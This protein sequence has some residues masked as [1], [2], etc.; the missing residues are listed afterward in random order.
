MTE[1]QKNARQIRVCQQLADN[2][3]SLCAN[4]LTEE[5]CQYYY[6]LV[7]KYQN[8]RDELIGAQS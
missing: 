2:Y 4:A 8:R 5:R 1:T 7:T 6:S 3:S